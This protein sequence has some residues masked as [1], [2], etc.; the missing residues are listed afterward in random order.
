MS[1]SNCLQSQPL[2]SQDGSS[3]GEFLIVFAAPTGHCC[4]VSATPSRTGSYLNVYRLSTK[5]LSSLWPYRAPPLDLGTPSTLS[6]MLLGSQDGSF[7]GELLTVFGALAGH[8]CQVSA[9]P[10]RMGLL[11]NIFQLFTKY[12]SPWFL[13][14]RA[15][16]GSKKFVTS[17]SFEK[18]I[19]LRLRR[20][21]FCLPIQIYRR[22]LG[23]KVGNMERQ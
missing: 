1:S 20:S 15:V 21:Y 11:L 19:L 6:L 16:H 2:R 22:L 18:K 10:S 3:E 13:P 23:A 12:I 7:E 8:F 17:K 14:R 5:Y 9:S 4:R